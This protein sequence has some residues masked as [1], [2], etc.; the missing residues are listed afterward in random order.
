M[1]LYAHK[2]VADRYAKHR[3]YF[4]PLV[5]NRIRIH[6]HLRQSVPRAADVGR[7]AGPFTVALKE[8]AGRLALKSHAADLPTTSPAYH[9]FDQERFFTRAQRAL[10]AE[11]WHFQKIA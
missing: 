4:H 7:G 2:T 6:L 9:W 3:L 1:N 11:A 8:N 10:R 5:I